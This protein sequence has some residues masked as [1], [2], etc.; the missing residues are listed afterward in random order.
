MN[1]KVSIK[2]HLKKLEKTRLE[3]LTASPVGYYIQTAEESHSKTL[4]HF[5]MRL[6]TGL[7]YT[8]EVPLLNVYS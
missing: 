2:R 5:L 4:H 1:Q 7:P 8:P 3:S 6:N